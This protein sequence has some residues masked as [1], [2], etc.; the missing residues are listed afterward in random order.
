MKYP[1]AVAVFYE[2]NGFKLND[3]EHF[4]PAYTRGGF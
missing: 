2:R 1:S 3:F 4:A